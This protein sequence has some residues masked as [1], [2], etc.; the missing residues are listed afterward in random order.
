MSTKSD[1]LPLLKHSKA[2]K[3]YDNKIT[4]YKRL[5]Q[6]DDLFELR[7]QNT[8]TMSRGQKE[9]ERKRQYTEEVLTES[10]GR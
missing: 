5:K 8:K 9:R 3:Q 1:H 2:Q 6:S 4:I 10:I 7:E